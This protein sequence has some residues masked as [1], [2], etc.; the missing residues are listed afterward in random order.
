MHP[1]LAITTIAT[2]R[3]PKYLEYKNLFWYARE[4]VAYVENHGLKNRSYTNREITNMF[5]SHIDN[6]YYSLVIKECRFTILHATTI[7][8]VYLVPAISST[9]DQLTP[10][11]IYPPTDTPTN[12]LQRR[13]EDRIQLLQEYCEDDSITPDAFYDHINPIDKPPWIRSFRRSGARSPSNRG[14]RSRGIFSHENYGGCDYRSNN[15]KAF[16]EKFNSRGML[17]HHSKNF[18]FLMKLQQALAYLKMKPSAPYKK[19]DTF[20]GKHSY[21]DST[22]YVRLLQD[23][24][25][26]PYDGADADNFIDVVDGDHH[27]FEPD[28]INPVDDEAEE[29]E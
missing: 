22:N 21:Q 17:G 2:I 23:A 9:I 15:N 11:K 4:I 5:L 26:I 19:R 1:L 7:N 3:I 13:H 28:I 8:A 25:F 18:H 27:V 14:G 16:K 6:P 29:R 20:R 24:G 10:S 12:Q